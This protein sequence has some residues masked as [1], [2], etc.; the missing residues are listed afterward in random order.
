L[1]KTRRARAPPAGGSPN[2][3]FRRFT[4]HDLR[5]YHAVQWLKSGRSIYVLKDRLGHTS[6]KTTEMYLAYLTAE[7]KN[8]VMF[9]RMVEGTKSG[10]NAAVQ[11]A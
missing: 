5:H 2:A 10:T 11:N 7:E 9:G 3:D 8:R 6:V 4:F 1:I